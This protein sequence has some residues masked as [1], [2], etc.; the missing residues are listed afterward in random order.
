MTKPRTTA[1]KADPIEAFLNGRECS[2]RHLELAQ[3][4]QATQG[5]SADLH[6][7]AAMFLTQGIA[8]TGNL[9][10]PVR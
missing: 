3:E 2:P 8:G 7:E 9:I 6:P 4:V 1:T 5:D 10:S